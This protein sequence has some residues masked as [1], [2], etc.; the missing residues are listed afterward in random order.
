[1]TTYGGTA[2]CETAAYFQIRTLGTIGSLRRHP[3]RSLSVKAE[4]RG[5]GKENTHQDAVVTWP[6][7]QRWRHPS[8]SPSDAYT[9]VRLVTR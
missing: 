9:N 2:P 6:S 7:V 8:V 4:T 1:M 5:H 3:P